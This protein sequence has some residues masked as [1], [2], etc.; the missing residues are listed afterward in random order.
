MLILRTDDPVGFITSDRPVTWFDPEAY[1]LPPFFRGPAL[2]SPTIEVT[3]PISP[4]QCLI[5]A[6]GCPSGYAEA[7]KLALD[8]LNRRHRALCGEHYVVRSNTKNDYWF[9]EFDL[10]DDA[11][12]KR[13]PPGNQIVDD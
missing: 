12:E 5:F 9:K 7:S 6:W 1:K 11:W 13:H 3:M 8:E 2:G 10:P 4:A